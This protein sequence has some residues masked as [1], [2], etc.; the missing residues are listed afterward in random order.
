MS[1]TL[2]LLSES[3]TQKGAMGEGGRLVIVKR[4]QRESRQKEMGWY[5]EIL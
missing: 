3:E 1:R 4:Y 2:E 5:G